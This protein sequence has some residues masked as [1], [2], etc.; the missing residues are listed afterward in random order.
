MKESVSVPLI[1]A[2]SIASAVAYS[3][4]P[5]PPPSSSADPASAAGTDSLPAWSSAEP[6]DQ[7]SWPIKD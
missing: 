5:P 6:K 4:S 1:C 3:S 7:D 2:E